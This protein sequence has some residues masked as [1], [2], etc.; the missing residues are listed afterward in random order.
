MARI[1]Q[2]IEIKV[3]VHAAYNQ[4]TQ[5]E[6]YPRFMEE[7]STVQQLDDTHLHWTTS[8]SNRPIEWDAEITEQV[9]DRCIAWRNISGPTNLGM[10]EV[11][12]I[13]TDASRVIF[14]LESK[15]EQVPGSAAGDSEEEMARRL[16]MDLA[17]LKEFMESRVS[18]TGAWRGEVHDTQLAMRDRDAGDSG[19]PAMQPSDPQGE[20]GSPRNSP[21]PT[22][23]YA[24]GSE[25]FSGEEEP[26]EPV[27]SASQTAAELRNDSAGSAVSGQVIESAGAL[28][29]S[30]QGA[31]QGSADG[32]QTRQAGASTSDMQQ[33]SQRAG[34]DA[35]AADAG[36]RQEAGPPTQQAGH[37]QPASVVVGAAGGTDA[38]AGARMSGSKGISTSKKAG[39]LP[40]ASSATAPAGGSEAA[41]AAAAGGNSLG[42]A[43]IGA[44]AGDTRSVPREGTTGAAG[45]TTGSGSAKP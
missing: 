37:P 7:V 32:Q 22:A 29:S 13:G 23:S 35:E 25:G 19:R 17:R 2:S 8:M 39:G 21:V 44:D 34:E 36:G 41:G 31:R 33:G 18:E 15:P 6:E 24:A 14:T 16:R 27:T 9:P 1:Q 20:R 45:G 40:D 5:F 11:Q 3:P 4:L 43:D 28:P 26:A 30:G 42:G 38:S 12:P 10:V